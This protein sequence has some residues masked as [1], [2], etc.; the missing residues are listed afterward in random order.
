MAYE[1][2]CFTTEG[3]LAI[4]TLNRP[5]RRNALSLGLM[6]ELIDC[7]STIGARRDLRAVIFAAA[8][9]VFSSG[10]DLTE[11]VGRDINAYRRLFDDCTDL[12]N[13]IQSSPQLVIAKVQGMSNAAGCQLGPTFHP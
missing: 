13:R 9:R 3:N 10:H 2:I 7:F 8:G 1:N 4:V 11:M 6:L 12:M 5:Q